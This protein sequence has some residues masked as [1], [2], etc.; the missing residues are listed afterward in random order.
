MTFDDSS[1]FTHSELP[2]GEPVTAKPAAEPRPRTLEGQ[3]V[4][5]RQVDP[6][7]DGDDLYRASHGSSGREAL[8]VYMAY[9]PF[10]SQEA[11]RRWLGER[12]RSTDPLFFTVI[13]N[14]SLKA[15]G[16]AAF[17]RFVPRNRCIEIAHVWYAPERQKTR[18]NTESIY[19]L[20][21]EAFDNL[22]YRRV[23]WKCDA[24]NLR[25]RTAALRLGFQFEGIFR[26]H[27]ISKG[28]NRDTAWFAM[29][30]GDWDPVKKAIERWLLSDGEL[31]L[32]R[33]TQGLGLIDE[34]RES[35]N[36]RSPHQEPTP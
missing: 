31:S 2:V 15:V 5:L 34:A 24:L 28:R 12:C 23:E 27:M 4:T 11:M 7:A 21:K 8:W 33:L 19:M 22:G 6:A 17:Q 25:S 14:A 18:V 9:G 29:I 36:Q 1:D 13:E 10:T 16:M 3:W 20:L 32:T 35:A 30:D 26:Q